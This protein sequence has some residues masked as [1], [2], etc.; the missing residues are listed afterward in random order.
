MMECIESLSP[1]GFH[2]SLNLAM[3]RRV[4]WKLPPALKCRDDNSNAQAEKHCLTS[5]GDPPK[6]ISSSSYANTHDGSDSVSS[7]KP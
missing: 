7:P 2:L 3:S 5:A 1:M 6:L 4:I